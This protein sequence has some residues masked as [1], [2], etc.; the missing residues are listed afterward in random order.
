[1]GYQEWKKIK[2]YY[3]LLGFFLI[4][5]SLVPKIFTPHELQSLKIQPR[6]SKSLPLMI[7]G[8][9]R[10]SIAK[11]NISYEE[12]F[13]WQLFPT[14]GMRL[15]KPFWPLTYPFL[16]HAFPLWQ[17]APSLGKGITVTILDTGIA[18]FDYKKGNNLYTK[19]PHLTVVG[20]YTNECHTV[21]QFNNL[22][23]LLMYISKPDGISRLSIQKRLPV[24]IREYLEFKTTEAFDQYLYTYGDQKLFNK[25]KSTKDKP[26][27]SDD[28]KR[29]KNRIITEFSK[30]HLI[31]L[32]PPYYQQKAIAEFLPLPDERAALADHGT[33]VASII[34]AALMQ[35]VTSFF[36][37]QVIKTIFKA[38]ESS[39]CGL[40]PH[41]SLR[42][43]K[44]LESEK[45]TDPRVILQALQCAR[46]F[47]TD[48]LNLSFVFDTYNSPQDPLFCQLEHH[49][50]NMPYVCACA[51][52]EG[53]KSTSIAYPATLDSISFSVGS[54]EFFYDVTKDTY[55]CPLSGFSQYEK[56][57]GPLYV[58][59]GKDIIGCSYR[60]DSTELVYATYTGTSYATPIMTGFL[61]LLLGEF[62]DTFSK[63]EL[64]YV[65]E[66]SCL[67]LHDTPEWKERVV[68]G[69]LDMR[70]VLFTLHVITRLQKTLAFQK[71]KYSFKILVH[72]VHTILFNMA[73]EY[74]KK[75]KVTCTFKEGYID[76]FNDIQNKKV[77]DLLKADYFS[78][79]E[80]AIEYVSAVILEKLTL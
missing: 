15:E 49:I 54:F 45:I 31:T 18:A 7:K 74:G 42:M 44:G 76:Y 17:M 21:V 63:K 65:C 46:A 48:I 4:Y 70:T 57:R 12:V 37:T 19:N 59:P 71:K 72:H 10:L 35:P 66:K 24:W 36:T 80:R 29:F 2:I 30:Y 73:D 60:A 26:T 75:Q 34:G 58:A 39:F 25:K 79:F 33:H 69:V 51:G 6:A 13:W 61:A 41:C 14:T 68:Y 52:N 28:G 64:L 3:V 32:G 5:F 47:P 16:P 40:A 77:P 56:N 11:K 62:K 78:S 27:F 67:K 55:Y 1:M 23:D 22:V 20:D 38:G 9:L 43:I 53:Q 50:D 8:K